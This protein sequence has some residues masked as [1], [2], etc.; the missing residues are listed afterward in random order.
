MRTLKIL[1]SCALIVGIIHWIISF[2]EFMDEWYNL[3]EYTGTYHLQR[4][5]D[6]MPWF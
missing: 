5:Y 2:F 1:I 6:Y 3:E 4:T